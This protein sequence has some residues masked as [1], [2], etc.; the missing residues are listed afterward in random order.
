MYVDHMDKQHLYSLAHVRALFEASN[1][2]LLES[3]GYH[4]ATA[5]WERIFAKALIPRAAFAVDPFTS[6]LPGF[7]ALASSILVACQKT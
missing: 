5:L 3:R 2:H 6:R 7:R 4:T 1:S